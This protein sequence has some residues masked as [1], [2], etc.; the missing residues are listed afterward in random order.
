MSELPFMTVFQVLPLLEPCYE[1]Q[2]HHCSI[3]VLTVDAL[4]NALKQTAQFIH[5]FTK[6]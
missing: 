5:L 3:D 2:L 6:L 4:F 1:Q